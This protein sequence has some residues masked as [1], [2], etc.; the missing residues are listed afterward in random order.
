MTLTAH[1]I[2][3]FQAKTIILSPFYS[4]KHKD[5]KRKTLFGVIGT[6][7]FDSKHSEINLDRA[8]SIVVNLPLSALRAICNISSDDGEDL[9]AGELLV[10]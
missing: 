2:S 10:Y 5:F 6:L 4:Q 8:R 1:K 9:F 7:S 3:S